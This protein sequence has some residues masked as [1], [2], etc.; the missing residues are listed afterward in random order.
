MQSTDK[1]KLRRQIEQEA[2]QIVK[3]NGTELAV[4]LLSICNAL[5]RMAENALSDGTSE[6]VSDEVYAN[7][8]SFA[9]R[10]KHFYEIHSKMG[11]DEKISGEL[12]EILEDIHTRRDAAAALKSQYDEAVTTNEDLQ[13]Q[14]DNYK[15]EIQE[16]IMV[17]EGLDKMLEEC[18]PEVIEE[19]KRI[20]DDL[21]S[22]LT[23]QKEELR[24]LKKQQKQL[25]EEQSGV[26]EDVR[27]TEEKI[28]AIPEE[29][30]Q[31][32]NKF[33]ELEQIL[34]ELQTAD[35]E[36]SPEKQKELQDRIEELTPVVEENKVA[37]EILTNRKESLEQQSIM[38][39]R[40][41]QILTT[42]LTDL[43]ISSL[44]ELKSVLKEYERF[45]EETENTADK[46]A[47]NILKCQ[48][49]REEYSAWYDSIKTPLDAMIEGLDYP[50]NVDLRK[51]LDVGQLPTVKNMLRDTRQNLLQLDQV[52][53]RCALAAQNDLR[54]VQRRA[55][56]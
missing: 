4:S 14:I 15:R 32:R 10:I 22:A 41:R 3:L 31:L 19:Q 27:N 42:N 37:T 5:M 23:V 46:L 50:E 1:Q 35:I 39:D 7:Y 53:A 47:Q 2:E 49:R 11:D 44:A 52:L 18:R 30:V 24:S 20:N 28:K 36:Y 38:Y 56:Q 13:T 6:S 26:L 29:L 34:T 25:E 43:I 45:L 55:G 17:K 16:Q 9:V 8:L 21:F 40:T 51:T 12:Q 33:K 48:Q 54:R